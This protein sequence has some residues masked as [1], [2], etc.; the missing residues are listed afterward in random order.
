M[1]KKKKLPAQGTLVKVQ[2]RQISIN[3]VGIHKS[4]LCDIQKQQKGINWFQS[5]LNL[6]RLFA[7]TNI[8]FK[9]QDLLFTS[10]VYY[11]CKTLTNWGSLLAYG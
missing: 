3:L 1:V 6:H 11:V 4:K 7:T 5:D 9:C 10:L 8:D 2:L